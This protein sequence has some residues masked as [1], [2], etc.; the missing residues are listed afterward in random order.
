MPKLIDIKKILIIGSGPIQ[1]GQG[2]EFDYSGTQAC[3]ALRDEGYEVV[4]INSN[5]ATIMTDKETADKVYIEPLTHEFI[6]KIIELERP[7]AI[8]PT[9][10]G[11][12]GLNLF[13]ELHKKGDLEKYKVKAIGVKAETVDK[14]E[15]RRE[16]KSLVTSLGYDVVRG[17]LVSTKEQARKLAQELSY[18][19]IIRAS[20]TL[21]G[22]GGGIAFDE[23]EFEKLVDAAFSASEH[24]EISIEESI[25]GWKEYELEVMRD[26]A[27]NFVVICGIENVNPMGVHTGDS[28]TVAPCMTLT[29]KEYQKLRECSK[30]IFKEIGMETGGAN[31]QFAINPDNGRTVVIEMNPRVSRSSALVSKATGYPI[32][33]ISAKLAIGLTLDEIKNEITNV[34]SAAFEPT[35]DYVV[36]KIPR[37]DFDKY[38][39]VDGKLGIQMKSVGEGLAFGRSFKDAFQKAWRSLEK[40]IDG[41]QNSKNKFSVNE[42]ENLL[43]TPTPALFSYIKDAFYLGFSIDKIYELTGIGKWFLYQ[44]QEL[45]HEENILTQSNSEISRSILFQAKKDGFS[46]KQIANLTKNSI[47]KIENL[48]KEFSIKPTFKM[49]DT[50]AGEFEAQTPYYFKTYEEQ[51]DNR[52][53]NN[54]KIVIL[55]SGPNRIGQG[56][57]FDYSCVHAVKAVQELGYEA[58]LINSNP[59]TVSTDFYI[60]DKL[61]ME[62]L[63]E[64]DILDILTEENPYG[65]FIQ[66]GG[67][68]PLKLAKAIEQKGFRILGTSYSAI[69]LAE[70]RNL[71]GK[72]LTKLSIKAPAFGTAMCAEDAI[73]VANRINYPVLV[74]P[75]F[76]LGG[77]GMA[78]V[79]NES[80]LLSYF[81]NALKIDS[82]KPVLIDKY[83][84]NAIEF[85]V[86]LICDGENI[87]IPAIM[88]HIEEAGIHSGDSSCVI[89]SYSLSQNNIDK[90]NIISKMLALELKTIGLMNIQFALYQ[91]EIYVLEVNPRSSRSVP[92]VSKATEI[93]MAKNAAFVCLGKKINELNT[94]I[95]Q[96]CLNKFNIKVP[97]FPF[98]KFPDFTPVLGPEMRSIGEVMSS[99][100]DFNE[101]LYKGYLSAGLKLNKSG[102]VLYLGD[103]SKIENYF[104]IFHSILKDNFD[105]ISYSK[106]KFKLE[107]IKYKIKNQEIIMI[108]SPLNFRISDNNCEVSEISKYAIQ[109]KIPVLSTLRSVKA[110]SIATLYNTMRS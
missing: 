5:P 46:N 60:S 102:I 90:I 56:V 84:E 93:P 78:V 9:M 104:N 42:L 108:I 55:G 8:L 3:L 75:S 105:F 97:V 13:M 87:F 4:L 81:K 58:I 83:L 94:N 11:Q 22:T 16:F 98:Q 48:L 45:I 61:Y 43:Q 96:H 47:L 100:H 69:E 68:S 50:C 28:V 77:K 33:R 30:V 20:F 109:Y 34:T 21:G 103:E 59:E 51:N 79:F 74:R 15:D 82:S 17:D 63:V 66:F 57:E 54:K 49:V 26:R 44:L 72:I 85:D 107:E 6:C 24:A 92:F 76:V 99:S 40:N 89:P 27:G 39:D 7:D 38:N 110:F 14:A 25:I 18:P 62:P 52:I 86:D 2:C 70:D 36:V 64:E 95:P 1:I 73:G 12:V 91:N 88:E 37:W 10:G 67:Q 101:M 29:D 23:N 106:F 71:F 31:I 35:I 32:A 65:V 80:E 41:W 53:S 19:L